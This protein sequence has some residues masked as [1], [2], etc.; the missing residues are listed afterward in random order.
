MANTKNALS[1]NETPS[2]GLSRKSKALRALARL[3]RGEK[4][5]KELLMTLRAALRELPEDSKTFPE[6]DIEGWIPHTPGICPVESSQRIWVKDCYGKV[7]SP[8][9]RP[10]KVFDWASDFVV[11]WREDSPHG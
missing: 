9:G 11:A 3:E 5:T 7:T 6:P 10:A 1:P 2:S 8:T 4:P